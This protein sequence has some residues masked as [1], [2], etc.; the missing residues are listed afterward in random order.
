MIQR[1]SSALLAA[2][3]PALAA[4]SS[5][6][7]GGPPPEPANW[8]PGQYVLEATV[9]SPSGGAPSGSTPYQAELVISPTGAMS[10]TSSAGLCVDPAQTAEDRARGQR[11]FRCGETTYRLRAGTGTVAGEI[12]APVVVETMVTECLRFEM[13]PTTG[14]NEC[15]QNQKKLVRTST[16]VR[17]Q[18]RVVRTNR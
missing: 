1:R 13:N 11:T 7:A 6:G 9:A 5:A 18:L 15:V 14:T 4:C 16:Q 10:L 12:T 2:L 8:E 3:V 17:A